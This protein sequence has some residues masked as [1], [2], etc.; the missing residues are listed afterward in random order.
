MFTTYDRR[1]AYVPNPHSEG[2]RKCGVWRRTER[3]DIGTSTIGN[4]LISVSDVWLVSGLKHNLSSISQ[5]YEN[6]YEVV[7]NKNLCSVINESEKSILFKGKRNW[8]V[9]KINLFELVDQKVA[10]LMSVSDEK[11]VR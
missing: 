1:K 9:Y 5:F 6:G 11:W 4:S 3:E 10:C 8:N 2:G 7:F